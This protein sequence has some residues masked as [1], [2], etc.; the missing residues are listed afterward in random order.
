MAFMDNGAAI[1]EVILSGLCHRF[2]KL[3]CVSVE[4][5]V[6]WV[7]FLLEALDWQWLNNGG[8]LEHSEFDLLPSGVLPAAGVRL[9]LVRTG[10]RRR[11]RDD[12]CGGG[13]RGVDGARCDG[14]TR[15]RRGGGRPALGRGI[16]MTHHSDWMRPQVADRAGR[17]HRAPRRGQGGLDFGAPWSV[18][19]P[20][21]SGRTA[22]ARVDRALPRQL[23]GRREVPADLKRPMAGRWRASSGRCRRTVR[24]RT[25][26]RSGPHR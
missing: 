10:G 24:H 18:H 19:G 26:G 16:R 1:S 14:R 9:L 4:S 25:C 13:R 3:K 6:G 12:R 8:F 5:G 23:P 15:R 2:P 11:G 7:P 20:D 17:C 22:P 21:A